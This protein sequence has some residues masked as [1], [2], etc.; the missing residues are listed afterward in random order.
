[1]ERPGIQIS[2]A[3]LLGVIA[4]V[5]LNI[6]LFRFGPLLGIVGLNLTKHVVIA[7]LCQVLGVDRRKSP[8]TQPAPASRA[9]LPAR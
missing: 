7:W 4:C 6:W 2:V 3:M 5:A 1:M 8:T 9:G